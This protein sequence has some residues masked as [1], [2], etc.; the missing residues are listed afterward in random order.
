[1]KKYIPILIFLLLNESCKK[2]FYEFP[3][4][5]VNLYLYPN[6]IEF[7]GLH[8]PGNSAKIN[9]GVNGILIFHDFFDNYIA[10]DRACTNNP[11][12]SCEQVDINV[13][14]TNNLI[15]SCCESEFFIFDGAV[16]IGPAQQSLHRY[17]TTFDGLTLRVFN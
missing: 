2:D 5:N 16:I 14:Q 17:Q 7:N 8:I 12:N 1:M 10:Y 4:A 9:G 6:N 13:Q 11:L 3:Q 15:C